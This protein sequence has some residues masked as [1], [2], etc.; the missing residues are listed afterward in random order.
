LLWVPVLS[1]DLSH[2]RYDPDAGV[3]RIRFHSGG[4]YEY[5]GVPRRAY[6]LLLAAP[7]KG[8]YFHQHIK[9]RYDFARI[10]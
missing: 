8:K 2:A 6:D 1:T 7:S 9:G 10:R 3:L 5:Y 4:V